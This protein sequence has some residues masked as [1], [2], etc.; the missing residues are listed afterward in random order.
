MVSEITALHTMRA[1][2][3]RT[4][5]LASLG[6]LAAGVAHEVNNPLA[7]LLSSL[8]HLSAELPLAVH[9]RVDLAEALRDAHEGAVRVRD[10]V[11]SLKAFS[12][13]VPAAPEPVEVASEVE[14][15]LRLASVE[16]RHRAR[17]LT[18]LGPMPRVLASP[19]ELGQVFLN[20]MVNA[21]QSI[22]EGNTTGNSVTVTA[23]T[24]P[25]GWA[26]V[27]VRDTGC[28]IAPEALGRVFEPFF[29]TKAPGT[30]T[31]LGLALAHGIVTAARGTIEVRSKPG[32][33][34]AFCVRLPPAPE[35]VAAAPAAAGTAAVAAAPPPS[36][37]R[38]V[39]VVD[40]DLLVARS[41]VRSLGATCSVTVAGSG[42][43]A[44]ATLAASP[45]FDVVLCDL[46]MPGMT[47]MELY[48]EVERRHPALRRRFVFLTGGAFTEGA[49]AFLEQAARAAL[50][51]PFDPALL[52][53]AVE[54]TIREAAA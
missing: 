17:L 26:F 44:L 45:P 22:P 5:R 25:R 9:G 46:M 16:I 7:Y 28:G 23:G 36:E 1:E 15:A 50:E 41:I 20:L 33:G 11:R 10:V 3:E 42:P 21:A 32:E 4:Q 47:G 30:G 51:K 52:R 8:D 13:P 39:L 29:T 2:L 35:E 43:E 53:Q 18:E 48:A 37:G 34:S 31:G 6:T 19:H 38:R 14:A 54:R 40:D 49:R 12:R 24:D 27:I